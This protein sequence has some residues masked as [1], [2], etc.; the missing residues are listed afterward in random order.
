MSYF[1]KKNYAISIL[2]T[3]LLIAILFPA[4]CFAQ[5]DMIFR[6]NNKA[7]VVI[8]THDGA[9]TAISQ[10]SGFVVRQD[11]VIV[12]N[13]HVISGAKSI[14][15]KAGTNVYNITGIIN[16]DKENDIAI[17]KANANNLP[18]VILGDPEKTNIG[19]KIYVISSPQGLENTISDGILS[20]K[21]GAEDDKIILQITAPVSP[22]SSGGP[23]FNQNGQVIGVATFLLKDSQ[24]LNFAMPVDGIKD[25]ITAKKVAAIK[26]RQIENYSKT[27][28]YWYNLGIVYGKSGRYQ[29]AIE[30]FKEAI[31]INPDYAE[32][33]NGLGAIYGQSGKLQEAIEAFKQAIRIK[34]GFAKPHANLGT[35]YGKLNRLQEAIQAL[36]Q[37][38]RINPDYAEAYGGLGLV[39][40][41]S[42]RYQEAIEAFKEGIQR[43]PDYAEAYGGLGFAY[44][45]LRKYSE[46]LEASKQAIQIK[47]DLAACHFI[48]GAVYSQSG[49]YQDAIEAFRE[50]IRIKPDD[51]EA[52]YQLGIVYTKLNNTSDALGEYTIL[53]NLDPQRGK[54]LF[55]VIYK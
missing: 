46:A 11:G 43:K 39:Y 23:V 27:A 49:R 24:N 42:G 34:P 5:A 22:G 26:P 50:G 17:L 3:L 28:E 48:L 2:L 7:V 12:T 52:H 20:G 8:M 40:G 31:R 6:Q 15:I 29:E 16:L 38:I 35:A 54:K 10:G 1:L 21:R 36:K 41:K 44:M 33:H 37:A 47:P 53:K 30:A 13:Y 51:A 18:T 25:K 32:A 4:I 45:S 14:R 19:E 55:D 9:G